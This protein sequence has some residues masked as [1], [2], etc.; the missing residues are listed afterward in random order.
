M[1]KSIPAHTAEAFLYSGRRNPQWKLNREQMKKWKQQWEAAPRSDDQAGR[2][3]KLG[4]TGCL[5]KYE[6]HSYWIIFNG[7]VSFYDN[8]TVSSKRDAD[9]QM[10]I[11]LL[12]TGPDEVKT[13]LTGIK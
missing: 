4:Y 8:D 6:E 13:M 7:C 9:R 10:E 11:W 12:S 2:L 3:S 1:S 5:L